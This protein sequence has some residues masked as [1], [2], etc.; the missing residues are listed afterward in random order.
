MRQQRRRIGRVSEQRQQQCMLS[1]YR[2]ERIT[3]IDLENNSLQRKDGDCSWSAIFRM[4]FGNEGHLHR[5]SPLKANNNAAGWMPASHKH[6]ERTCPFV[7]TYLPCPATTPFRGFWILLSLSLRGER[8]LPLPPIKTV[9][10]PVGPPEML[11]V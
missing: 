2:K 11:C 8:G 3:F 4:C 1:R 9:F 10:L 5:L 6:S 7:L